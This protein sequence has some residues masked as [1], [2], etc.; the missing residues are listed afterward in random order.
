MISGSPATKVGAFTFLELMLVLALIAIIFVSAAPLVS[1][2]L[3]ER[4]LRADAE[5]ISSMVRSQRA[6]AQEDGRRHVLNIR[7]GGFF[8]NGDP[9]KEIASIPNDAIFT[10]RYPGSK[11]E[12]P[13][14][15]SWEFSPIGMVTPL[16]IRLESGSAWIEVDFDMLTGRVSEE[17]YAF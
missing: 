8:E 13:D 12:K 11:W 10:L 4:R 7:P 1:A 14:D 3:R 9:P 17:R 5:K 6:K 15:Q 2:S 16:S